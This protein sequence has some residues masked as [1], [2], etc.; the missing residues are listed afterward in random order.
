MSGKRWIAAFVCALTNG[1]AT[2]VTDAG[3][4]LRVETFSG[5]GEEVKGALCRLENDNGQFS[6]V[7][8]GAVTVRKSSDDLLIVCTEASQTDAKAVVRSRVGVGIFG[9]II[10][11][12]GVG[13]II[14]H[15]KGS[16]YNYPTWLQLVFG[17]L[18][19]FD[20]QDFEEGKPTPAFELKDGKR[21][22]Y[23]RPVFV[24]GDVGTAPPMQ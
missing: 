22:A 14:D 17:R 9:N 1:C 7:T 15:A 11:G 2:I 4:S 13:A 3:Q 19:S 10:F 16:A 24:S 20:R 6:V 21:E 8:P 12:G 18:L 23:T 5:Q